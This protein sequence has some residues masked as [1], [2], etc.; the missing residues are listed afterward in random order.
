MAQP[1]Y[2]DG[3]T[4]IDAVS[5]SAVEL[6]SANTPAQQDFARAVRWAP[7]SQSLVTLLPATRARKSSVLS[8]FGAD[9]SLI[10][11]TTTSHDIKALGPW[12][13]S[14]LVSVVGPSAR[15]CT[16]EGTSKDDT[17]VGT[18]GS[19]VICGLG[20]DD[21]IRP[22][23]GRDVI[24]GGDGVDMVDF[25][26]FGEAVAANLAWWTAK[27]R[28]VQLLSGIEGVVGS[29]LD[30]VLR[31]DDSGNWF[32]GGA[33]RDV[34]KGIAGNDRLHGGSDGDRLEGA[35]GADV[36]RGDGG[37]DRLVV[38]AEDDYSGGEGK[39]LCRLDGASWSP[40]P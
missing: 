33:G 5:G 30:D 23:G 39:D 9:G 26:R 37:D 10:R 40:C 21:V 32:F 14:S 25:S 24:V 18:A 22:R 3:L 15:R 17:L 7:D 8:V 4:L 31:G 2:E 16:I 11:E 36:V 6:P 35:A 20:G 13:S 34:I 27:D 29:P 38:S 1:P 19:D 12:P 28:G